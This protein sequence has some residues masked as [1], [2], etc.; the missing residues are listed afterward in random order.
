MRQVFTSARLVN[1]EQVAQMLRDAG[2]EVKVTEGKSFNKGGFKGARSYVD[3][4]AKKPA[5]WVVKSD[6]QVRAREL[7]RVQGLIDS[8]RGGASTYALPAFHTLEAERNESPSAKR[9]FRI[10]MALITGIVIVLVVTLL[11]SFGTKSP[12]AAAPVAAAPAAPA[13]VA[14]I[15]TAPFGTRRPMLVTVA[16]AV[17]VQE[18]AKDTFP[19]I[20]IALDGADAPADLLKALA[21]PGRTMLPAS[22][23]RRVAD[24][25]TGSV[26][27][28]T[29]AEALVV[30]VFN[31]VPSG[32]DAGTV[33]ID[34]YFHRQS[35]RYK[36]LQV[37]RA[38]N[39]WR[40][41]KTVKFVAF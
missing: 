31:F 36:T 4:E 13:P 8:T 27:L 12:A 10:K 11:R 32:P 1:V 5:V 24:E 35:A 6:D 39:A 38:G 41:D 34:A 19:A 26:T 40:I 29:G 28:A 30:D 23:C 37:A 22:R 2:I 3:T 9:A 21:K 7:L 18:L 20:C 33:Q 25:A 16:R 17:L 14:E 15:A